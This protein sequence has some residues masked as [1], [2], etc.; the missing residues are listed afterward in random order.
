MGFFSVPLGK[1]WTISLQTGHFFLS[2]SRIYNS[3]IATPPS[4]KRCGKYVDGEQY[5]QLPHLKAVR[6]ECI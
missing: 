3:Q 5:K 1:L 2:I 4:L 6:T